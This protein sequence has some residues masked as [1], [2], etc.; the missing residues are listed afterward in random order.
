MK[1]L[2][3]LVA[4]LMVVTA[5]AQVTIY[6]QDFSGMPNGPLTGE[7]AGSG[8]QQGGVPVVVNDGEGL[9]YMQLEVF[10]VPA[11][12]AFRQESR[13]VLTLP[14]P[15]DLT[16]WTSVKIEFDMTLP[17]TGNNGHNIYWDFDNT[18]NKFGQTRNDGNWARMVQGGTQSN[19]L[20]PP[21]LVTTDN[22]YHMVWDFNLA[23]T[24]SVTTSI[25]GNVIDTAYAGDGGSL[26]WQTGG[27]E[28]THLS[29]ALVKDFRTAP[30]GMTLQLDNFLITA[31]PEPASL[32]L[33]G[34]AGLFI[35][36]R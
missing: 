19:T 21:V 17:F 9:A 8:L 7:W 29:L 12:N 33:V 25:N 27:N 30:F 26:F 18:P 24:P 31:V 28:L 10:A 6:Q 13:A 4:A 3:V 2:A 5:S 36:R 16:A 20:D 23:G 34:L 22:T 14:N 15:V 35:R 1:K 11:D 32:L